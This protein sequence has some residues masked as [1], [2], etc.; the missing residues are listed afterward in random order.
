MGYVWGY[1][2]ANDRIYIFTCFLS[3]GAIAVDAMVRN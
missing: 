2:G 1:C 3:I